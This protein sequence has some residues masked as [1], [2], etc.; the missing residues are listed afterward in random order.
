MIGELII[1]I[2]FYGSI[3]YL[4]VMLKKIFKKEEE[5]EWP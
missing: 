5:K 3:A 4:V 1:R 2:I